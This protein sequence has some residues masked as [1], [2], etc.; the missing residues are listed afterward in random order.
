MSFLIVLPS[1]YAN[2]LLFCALTGMR[3]SEC[4]ESITLLNIGSD[5]FRTYYNPERQ[6]LQHYL[7]PNIFI[8][9]TKAIY[10]S[11][12]NDEIIGLAQK[13]GNNPQYKAPIK[14]NKEEMSEHEDKIL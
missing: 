13:I 2:L 9:R 11:I 14:G 10:I 8:R 1:Q 12:V 4:I 3:G 7:Y 5:N 6:I